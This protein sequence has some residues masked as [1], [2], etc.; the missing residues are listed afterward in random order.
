M[1][2]GSALNL[3]INEGPSTSLGMTAVGITATTCA[4]AGNGTRCEMIRVSRS[5]SLNPNLNRLS[6]KSCSSAAPRLSTRLGPALLQRVNLHDRD[7]C[8]SA[9]PAHDRGVARRRERA[10]NRGFQIVRRWDRA[11][12]DGLLV[13]A[14]NPVVV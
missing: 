6:N 5:F 10:H 14:L 13:W 1:E 8:L 12:D 3:K 9:Y 4:T 7:A 11:V 2:P